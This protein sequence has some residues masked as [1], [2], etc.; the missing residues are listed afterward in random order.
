KRLLAARKETKNVD[1]KGPKSWGEMTKDEKHGII[2]DILGMSNTRDGGTLIFGVR[3]DD[4]EFVGVPNEKLAAF[5]QTDINNL[6]ENFTEPKHYC[7]VQIVDID[8]TLTAIIEVPEFKDEPIICKKDRNSSKKPSEVILRRGAIYIRNEKP[9]TV[10][11]NTV[12]GMRDLLGRAVRKKRDYLLGEI[13]T[14][15]EGK[16]ITSTETDEELYRNE[17]RNARESITNRIGDDFGYWDVCAYPVSYIKNRIPEKRQL[18]GLVTKSV[19]HSR[20]RSFPVIRDTRA[21][22]FEDGWQVFPS[23]DINRYESYFRFRE[24]FRVYKSGLFLWRGILTAEGKTFQAEIPKK[25]VIYS[26][27]IYSI[28]DYLK[29]LKRYFE[30]FEPE[31]GIYIRISM[32]G[33]ADRVLTDYDPGIALHYGSYVSSEDMAFGVSEVTVAELN[34]SYPDIANRIIRELLLYFNADEITPETIK[35]WQDKYLSGVY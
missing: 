7:I 23:E 33:V 28:T 3:D 29:F 19:V 22:F 9:E 34:S 2:K 11:V 10:E 16:P 26:D 27:M 15:L 4:C 20:G 6:L 18:K 30:D 1:Y 25:V 12:E 8:G 31:T 14:I 13:V 35:S 21:S 32:Y 17:I 24:G 5:D